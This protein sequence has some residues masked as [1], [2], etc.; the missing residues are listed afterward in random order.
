[1]R[2]VGIY[3]FKSGKEV[4]EAKFATELQEIKEIIA[5]VV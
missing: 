5:A 4:I 1:V 2:I 3:S